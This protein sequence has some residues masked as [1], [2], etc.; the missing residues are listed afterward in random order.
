MSSTSSGG[1]NTIS[2]TSSFGT[3]SLSGGP[4]A[5]GKDIAGSH[6]TSGGGGV[7]A[8]NFGSSTAAFFTGAIPTQIMLANGQSISA[9]C[10]GYNIAIIP[11]NG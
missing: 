6:V 7:A 9:V 8:Q 2:L 3:A 4:S 10:G 1:N 11:E 5:I